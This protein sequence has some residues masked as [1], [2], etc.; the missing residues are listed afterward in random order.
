M[1]DP[2]DRLD[3]RVHALESRFDRMEAR[4]EAHIDE[5]RRINADVADR[6]CDLE[7]AV[8]AVERWQD[9]QGVKI[10]VIVVLSTIIGTAL[11]NAFL[12][13]LVRSG[14]P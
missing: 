8:R 10:A 4:D 3:D 12:G 2:L 5:W 1:A 14:I 6:L 11:A 9:R 13:E 7:T